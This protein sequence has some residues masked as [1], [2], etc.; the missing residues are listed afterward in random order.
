M[1]TTR[2]LKSRTAIIVAYCVLAACSDRSL[3][4][5]N[6]QLLVCQSAS[7]EVCESPLTYASYA[8]GITTTLEI[9]LR[10]T[11]EI[12]LRITHLE[13]VSGNTIGIGVFPS[14]LAPN[15]QASVLLTVTPRL[16]ANRSTLQIQSNDTQRPIYRFDVVY[17]GHGPELM[18]CSENHRDTCNINLTIRPEP[19]KLT[20]ASEI[21]IYALNVSPESVKLNESVA[22]LSES[23]ADEIEILT[24]LNAGTIKAGEFL[25]IVIG[26]RPQDQINDTIHISLV[27]ERP[28]TVPASAMV[29]LTTPSNL[30][31]IAEISA[32]ESAHQN[33]SIEIEHVLWLDGRASHDPEGDPLQFTWTL[34][35]KPLQSA[36]LLSA[37]NTTMVS[38]IPDV[39]GDYR[40]D[41]IVTDSLNNTASTSFQIHV[42]PHHALSIKLEWNTSTDLDLHLIRNHGSLFGAD[43]CYFQ[44]PSPDWGIPYEI[45][46]D[47]LLLRDE[48]TGGSFEKIIIKQP[49]DGEYNV[50]VHAF[51]VHETPTAAVVHIFA[52]DETQTLAVQ[53]REIQRDCQGWLVGTVSWPS[54]IFTPASTR[55]SLIC[56]PPANHGEAL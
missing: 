21:V 35:E 56:L 55:P 4:P 7:D 12:P 44:N 2:L 13:A 53:T 15:A 16:G 6:P 3:R 28:F 10:N 11:G 33:G 20:R 34:S 45:F 46:D 19:V 43:D 32:L 29:T 39:L 51:N 22:D 5:L 31:P 24:S 23:V 42:T 17:E 18:F 36:S 54:A 48:E 47:P 38:L 9:V 14:V 40:V 27:P 1:I 50:I 41:L 49:S 25:P 30:P 52:N 37:S 8:A 26:Y